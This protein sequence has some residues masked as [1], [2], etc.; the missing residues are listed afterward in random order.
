MLYNSNSSDRNHD[1]SAH[2]YERPTVESFWFETLSNGKRQPY[3]C[4]AV[5]QSD[6][7]EI[8]HWSPGYS[9]LLGGIHAVNV[10]F[11]PLP[12]GR[13]CL[14]RTFWA[15]DFPSALRSARHSNVSLTRRQV[16]TSSLEDL[17]ALRQQAAMETPKVRM[18][19]HAWVI[20]PQTLRLFGSH[21]LSLYR[22]LRKESIG[23]Q[24]TPDGQVYGQS[25]SP[26]ETV[27]ATLKTLSR[28]KSLPLPN[29]EFDAMLE[30]DCSMII[31]G[32][33]NLLS[34]FDDRLSA[35]SVSERESTS[36]CTSLKFSPDRPFL[37]TGIGKSNAELRRVR[38]HFSLPVWDV[39]RFNAKTSG[40][41]KPFADD[42]LIKLWECL[43]E[44]L[45]GN[46]DKYQQGVELWNE[47]RQKRPA[48]AESALETLLQWSLD[49]YRG[50][51]A[52]QFK[53]TQQVHAMIDMLEELFSNYQSTQSGSIIVK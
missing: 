10:S 18:F 25:V 20:F 37:M 38:K 49:A 24:V 52:M 41:S 9:D 45:W 1:S 26:K 40:C 21:P 8:Y 51:D 7:R 29:G 43:K 12:S 35:M 46:K 32:K 5:C 14:S 15:S 53:Q 27:I 2:S 31:F 34:W 3:G 36:F 47:Y 11:H 19:T 50:L 33:T 16:D 44:S 17:M 42:E 28:R 4:G 22:A 13:Y 30:Q 39:R 48:M 23:C 6:K